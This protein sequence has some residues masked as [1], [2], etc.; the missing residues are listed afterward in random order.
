MGAMGV[1]GT[2]NLAMVEEPLEPVVGAMAGTSR[3]RVV[4]EA[5]RALEWPD[6][7]VCAQ[8]PLVKAQTLR[9]AQGA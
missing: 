3:F 1:R 6:L 5:L 9:A 7:A 2:F 8:S 4:Q